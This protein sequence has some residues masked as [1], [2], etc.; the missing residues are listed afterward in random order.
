[1]VTYKIMFCSATSKPYQSL[2][3]Q[4]HRAVLTVKA[5]Q[6]KGLDPLAGARNATKA[7]SLGAPVVPLDVAGDFVRLRAD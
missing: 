4:K 6:A 7:A 1:M 5:L 3:Q 2:A